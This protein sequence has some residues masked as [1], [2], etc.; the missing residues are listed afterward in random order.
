MFWEIIPSSPITK[1]ITKILDDMVRLSTVNGIIYLLDNPQ[2]HETLKV[3]LSRLGHLILD[4]VLSIRSAVVDLLLLIMGIHS[5]QFHMVVHLD[6]LL[7]TL[8]NDQPLVAQKITKLLLPS[9]FPTNVTSEEAC[10]RCVT[11]IKRSPLAGARFC[12]FC[13]SEGASPQSLNLLFKI[14]I[15]LVLSPANISSDQIDGILMAAA[16]I[17]NNLAT[18]PKYKT[19]LKKV[20]TSKKLM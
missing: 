15:N 20:L 9:Y 8:A 1:L 5:F 6:V 3:I 12:E 16:N 19:A 14:L 18:K 17:C 10:N 11:L 4:P 13:L 7:S 2:S